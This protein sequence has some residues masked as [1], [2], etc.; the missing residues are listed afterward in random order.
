MVF[1][2]GDNNLDSFGEQDVFEMLSVRDESKYLRILVEYDYASSGLSSKR[3]IIEN[4][5]IIEEYPLGETNTGSI[6]TLQNFIQWGEGYPADKNILILWNH[7]GGTLDKA[8]QSYYPLS[9]TIEKKLLSES[10]LLDDEAEDYLDNLELKAVFKPFKKFDI[11]GFDA[12]LMSMIEVLY[13]LRNHTEVIVGSQ[14]NQPGTGW[15]YQT[16]LEYLVEYPDASNE[17]ISK[18]MVSSYID[19]YRDKRVF[20]SLSAIRTNQLDFVVNHLNSFS[21][22]LLKLCDEPFIKDKLLAIYEKME[23]FSTAYLDLYYFVF[24]LKETF[25]DSHTFSEEATLL[26]DA[27]QKLVIDNQT[28]YIDKSYGLSIYLPNS[29]ELSHFSLDILSKLDINRSSSAPYWFKFFKKFSNIEKSEISSTKVIERSSTMAIIK[30]ETF[31]EREEKQWRESF[32]R[33][34]E[35]NSKKGLKEKSAEALADEEKREK[36]RKSL[37]NSNDYFALERIIGEKDLLSI[38]YLT[39][40]LKAAKSVARIHIRTERGIPAGYGTGFLISDTL[41][42][43]N[44][45]V[46]PDAN[47]ARHSQVEFD[48]EMDDN[49]QL[50]QSHYFL[51]DSERFFYSC[52]L[53][54][55]TIVSV[56][57][58]SSNSTP[59]KKFGYLQLIEESG[60][61]L[62]GEFISLIQHPKGSDKHLTIRNNRV[63][64]REKEYILYEADTMKGS[65][66]APVFNDQWDVVALHHSGVP[67]KDS[68]GR[69]LKKDGTPWSRTESDETIDWIANEGVR[70][71]SIFKHLKGKSFWSRDDARVLEELG[72]VSQSDL[73]EKLAHFAG[74]KNIIMGEAGTKQQSMPAVT[75]LKLS[76]L[77]TMLENPKTTEQDLS[78][79][80]VLSKEEQRGMDPLFKVNHELIITDAPEL[81]ESSLLLNSAN[82]ICK[83]TRQKLYQE[84]LTEGEKVKIISQGDSWFQY[85]FILNDVIDHL[86][87]VEN[88]A[89]LSFGEAGDLIREM[90]A[91]SEFVSALS[92]EK[93]DFFLISGGLNDLV[94]GGGIK[95]YIHRPESSF[96]PKDLVNRIAFSKFKARL[97]TDYTNLFSIIL[98]TQPH[99][100]ILF[101]GYSYPVPS[102]G[103]WLG[104]EFNTLGIVDEQLQMELVQILFD[105]INQELEQVSKSFPKSVHFLDIR[106]VVP[107]RGWFDELHPTNPFFGDV[108]SVFQD[109]IEQILYKK[110]GVNRDG[111]SS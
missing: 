96:D 21:F 39:R 87:Q 84:R 14:E 74:A 76:A 104:L 52:P 110:K 17:S 31:E 44:H 93:P 3:F 78:P 98:Q 57:P 82:W 11:I 2:A 54:D 15:N 47:Y 89:I 36:L 61:S 28:L 12:C 1:I 49:Y 81:K 22:A 4:G 105:E 26:L 92:S 30:S 75:Q 50:K 65:S 100:N 53:L 23:K 97:S 29:N 103:K 5:H 33:Y 55:F 71:S 20:V 56:R 62:T 106:N 107:E 99:I 63:L 35:A 108:A 48:F 111:K 70:I 69:I 80:F 59:L 86:M 85:P 40:G 77:M 8:I 72:K 60:K 13:Q 90:V 51:F 43:T 109:K 67:K 24:L 7:G 19:S 10:I 46:L 37:L 42:L 9:N 34:I 32:K 95:N 91:K 88:Y 94:S 6:V 83:R 79:Y 73:S 102:L 25:L 66:G 41:L 38:N 64:G 27:L 68:E 16:L 18:A 101:H 45:H 58:R